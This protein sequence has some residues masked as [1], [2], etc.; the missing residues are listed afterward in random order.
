MKNKTI[1][2]PSIKLN[3]KSKYFSDLE[4]KKTLN[5]KRVDRLKSDYFL[6]QIAGADE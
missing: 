3:E 4:K 5:A 1:T 6:D 2:N